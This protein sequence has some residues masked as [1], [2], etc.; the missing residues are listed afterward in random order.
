VKQITRVGLRNELSFH[1][2]RHS[3]INHC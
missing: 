3:L 1:F 2:D